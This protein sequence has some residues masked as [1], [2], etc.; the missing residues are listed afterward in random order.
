MILKTVTDF[1]KEISCEDENKLTQY[2][3]KKKNGMKCLHAN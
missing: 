2:R 1:S 3:D